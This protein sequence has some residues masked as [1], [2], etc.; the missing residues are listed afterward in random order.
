MMPNW[1]KKRT[2]VK[3]DPIAFQG[4]IH[5][6]SF[7]PSSK[8]KGE[9]QDVVHVHTYKALR[10]WPRAPSSRSSFSLFAVYLAAPR[11]SV[12]TGLAKLASGREAVERWLT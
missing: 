6:H 2:D 10:Q 9:V 8:K 4:V 5:I 11:A 3:L 7:A 12:N 1:R